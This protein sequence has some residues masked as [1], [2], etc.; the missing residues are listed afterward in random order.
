MLCCDMLCYAIEQT[1][2]LNRGLGRH[3]PLVVVPAFSARGH[4][5]KVM[6]MPNVRHP[7]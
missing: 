6:R 1:V 4:M 3:S 2:V 7:S 5:R